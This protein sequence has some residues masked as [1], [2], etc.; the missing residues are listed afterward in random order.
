MMVMSVVNLKQSC[1]WLRY[2]VPKI[3][4]WMTAAGH[5]VFGESQRL[6]CVRMKPDLQSQIYEE[7]KGM[8]RG[9]RKTVFRETGFPV[10]WWSVLA[11]ALLP[12][13]Y[14]RN[15]PPFSIRYQCSA[16]RSIRHPYPIP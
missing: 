6:D 8:T 13:G 10:D 7:T 12:W 5:T 1:G 3:W 16:I 14:L 15:S 2:R 4:I 9:G 11:K